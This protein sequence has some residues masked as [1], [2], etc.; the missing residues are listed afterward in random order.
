MNA[1]ATAAARAIATYPNGDALL[2]QWGELDGER[3]TH[4]P[5]FP[6][7]PA[8]MAGFERGRAARRIQIGAIYR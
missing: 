7:S 6:S 5:M 3:T 2:C 1:T 4:E 8:Y